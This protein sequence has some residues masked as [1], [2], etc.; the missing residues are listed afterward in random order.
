[1]IDVELLC[2]GGRKA[3][4]CKADNFVNQLARAG[5]N[6]DGLARANRPGCFDRHA[7]DP[8]LARSAGL[9]GFTPGLEAAYRP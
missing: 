6:G 2:F 9:R 7:I 5:I 4:G 1:M 3:F 8:D